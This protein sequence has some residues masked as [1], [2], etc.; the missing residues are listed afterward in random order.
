MNILITGITGFVG[1]NLFQELNEKYNVYA[2]IREKAK[3]LFVSEFDCNYFIDTGNTEDLTNYIINN[4]IDGIIHLA[5]CY[6]K[7][8]NSNDVT[9]LIDSNVRFSTRLLEAASRGN[10]KWFINTGTFWQHYEGKDYS[11]VNLYAATKEAFRTI[12]KYYIETTN[13][14]F[15]TL[16]LN[17][18]YGKGDTRKKI[19]NLWRDISH[20]NETLN[21]SGGE[22]LIDIVHIYDVVSAYAALIE[23]LSENKSHIMNDT[24]YAVSSGKLITLK[25]LANIFSEVT[26]CKININ[27]GKTPYRDREVMVPWSSGKPVPGWKPNISLAQGIKELFS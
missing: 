18:T 22:Q 5:S 11:P 3:Q 19:M 10:V 6:I 4:R 20:S 16:M 12:S 13:L 7:D 21:M 1:K 24:E 23:K 17:D 26:G 25:K 2:I 14:K 15:V 9:E 27:W 8:H